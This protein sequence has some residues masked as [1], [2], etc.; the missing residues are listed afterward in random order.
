MKKLFITA[1]LCLSPA[2]ALAGD[3]ASSFHI[4]FH[5]QPTLAVIQPGVQVVVDHDEEVFYADH[6]YWA[7]RGGE[8]Y[9]ARH[10]SHAFAYVERDRVPAA[11]LSFELGHYRHYHP[12]GGHAGGH[13]ADDGYYDDDD[14][15]GHD[16]GGHHGG[17]HMHGH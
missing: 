13:G 11:L 3:H 9:R 8:W 10:H 17:S 4:S 15:H 16:H 6:H 2:F 7:H 5:T 1:A 14:D 12:G